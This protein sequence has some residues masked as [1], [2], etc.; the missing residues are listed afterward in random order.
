MQIAAEKG[1][2]EIVQI[3]LKRPEIDVNMV[4]VFLHFV[5][6]YKISNCFVINMVLKIMVLNRIPYRFYLIKFKI[7]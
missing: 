5:F 1:N 4:A 7:N 2:K 3:L 6:F